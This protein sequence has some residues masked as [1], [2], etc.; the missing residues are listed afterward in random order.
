MKYLTSWTFSFNLNPRVFCSG[1]QDLQL[2]KRVIIEL[3]ANRIAVNC[4]KLDNQISMRPNCPPTPP[5]A[6][7]I[8]TDFRMNHRSI[9]WVVF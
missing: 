8:N 7:C 3:K 4:F 5:D 9:D 1:I 6:A 2:L